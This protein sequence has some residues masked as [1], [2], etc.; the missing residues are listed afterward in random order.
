VKTFLESFLQ[1]Q[2]SGSRGEGPRVTAQEDTGPG[3]GTSTTSPAGSTR[4]CTG[5][6][7]HTL[8]SSV[9]WTGSVSLNSDCTSLVAL[10]ARKERICF[11]ISTPVVLLFLL[12]VLLPPVAFQQAARRAPRLYLRSRSILALVEAG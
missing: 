11:P 12:S 3:Q 4:I 5:V 7:A 2:L 8:P 9:I 6:V 1:G 10:D